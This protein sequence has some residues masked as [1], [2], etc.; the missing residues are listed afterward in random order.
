M[1]QIEKRQ[2]NH[3]FVYTFGQFKVVHIRTKYTAFKKVSET[4]TTLALL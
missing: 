2:F 3:F 1:H 4:V